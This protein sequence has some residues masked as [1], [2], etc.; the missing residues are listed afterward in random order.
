[1]G[2]SEKRTMYE[3]FE[4]KALK[5]AID[6]V[7]FVVDMEHC[8]MLA[9][10]TRRPLDKD[11]MKIVF[12]D[13]LRQDLMVDCAERAEAMCPPANG[14][15]QTIL[16]DKPELSAMIDESIQA[17][18]RFGVYYAMQEAGISWTPAE[19]LTPNQ[20]EV[21]VSRWCDEPLEKEDFRAM[22]RSQ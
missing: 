10:L 3:E 17:A 7:D 9:K 22:K 15:W 8:K 13:T 19:P 14:E 20:N 18:F 16:A 4:A 5:H 12:A 21:V 6:S 1:M 11:L 2:E